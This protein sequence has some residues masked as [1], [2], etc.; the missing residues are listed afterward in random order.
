MFNQFRFNL[1]AN[2]LVI[3]SLIVISFIAYSNILSNQLFYDD[4]ELIYRNV[5]VAN[6]KFFPQYFITNMVAGAGKSSN[7]YR[8]VLITSFALDHLFWK[9]NPFGYHLT[10]I[11]LHCLNGILLYYLTFKLFSRRILSFITSLLFI[12]HPIQTEAVAY[13]SGRTDLLYSFFCLSSLLCLIYYF[14]YKDHFAYYLC[15][16]FLFILALL[17]K[18]SAVI[19]PFLIWLITV[20][21][22]NKII[23]TKEKKSLIFLIIFLINFVYFLLRLTILNFANTLNFYEKPTIYSQNILVRIYTFSKVFFDYFA[24]LIFPK[25]LIFS[26]EIKYITNPF[27]FWVILFILLVII[28]L[29]SIIKSKIKNKLI[30][31]SCCWFLLSLLPV[32]GLIPINSIIAE[33]YLYLPSFG[34]FLIVASVFY[35]FWQKYKKMQTIIIVIGTIICLS[36]LLRTR[37]RNSDWSDPITFYTK[38]LKQSPGNIPMR[39]NLAMSFAEKGMIEVAIAEYKKIIEVADVYPNTHH[40]LANLYKELANYK[41]A[42]EEYLK[43]LAIDPNFYFSYFAL[44]DLYKI[45]GENE[46]LNIIIEKINRISHNK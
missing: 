44:R 34:F 25:E 29:T 45:T 40:N 24:M 3:L 41:K 22:N 11:I 21:W 16:L 31:F 2:L 18:E 1:R 6:I 42:E 9:K 38:S 33:H 37:I 23:I 39:H 19:L 7:M 15:G 14:F 17:S 13:A 12:I 43:A 10:S 36:L 32:S 46:K 27:N 20:I 35:S 28:F 8:P 4:E 30:I 5:Y 26:R